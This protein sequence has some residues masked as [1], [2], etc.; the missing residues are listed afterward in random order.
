MLV[1]RVAVVVVVL[2]EAVERPELRQV[3]AEDARVVHPPQRRRDPAPRAEDRQEQRLELGRGPPGLLGERGGG[4]LE[5]PLQLDVELA[6]ELLGVPEDAQDAGRVHLES[7]GLR[8]VEPAVEDDQPVGERGPPAAA[9]HRA[10]A[11]EPLLAA[12]DEAR[13]DAM[14]RARVAIVVAHERL[15]AE[16]D[17]VVLVAEALRHRRLEPALEDVLLR[18]GQEVE[19][20]PDAPDEGER[21]VR[22]VALLGRQ[23]P[24]VLELAERPRAESRR[25]EPERRVDVPEPPGRL[26]DVRLLE[27]HRAAVPAVA[28]VPLGQ[29][30]GEEL[31]VVPPVDLAAERL[32]EGA[33]Q[34]LVAGEHAGRLHRGAAGQV[35][36]GEGEAIVERAA[37]MADAEAEVPE[38]VEDL[39]RHPLDVRG[40][41]A[42]VD[43]HE[44]EVRGGVE[45]PPPVAAERDQDEPRRGMAGGAHLGGGRLVQAAEEVVHERRVG[46]DAL[47]AR[48]A[49]GVAGLQAVVGGGDVLAEDFQAGAPAPLGPLRLGADELLPAP[50]P[51]RDAG[52][53]PASQPFR[54]DASMGGRGCQ[55]RATIGAAAIDSVCGAASYDRSTARDPAAPRAVPSGLRIPPY[56]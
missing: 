10:V 26:L 12:G 11:G 9:A 22:R 17:L 4:L 52:A 2:D 49:V 15:D 36:P 37:G 50:S 8:E 34:A 5:G 51:P 30:L 19:L 40:D 54:T 42:P 31:R 53:P 1:D 14:D 38:R 43:E 20:V 47:G 16:A 56:P 44:V 48:R 23:V 46:A 32:L 24:L 3:G 33:E 6:P 28:L 35:R 27:V 55:T 7:A 13:G 29:H 21:R 45:L 41:L 18:A 39:L 25:G